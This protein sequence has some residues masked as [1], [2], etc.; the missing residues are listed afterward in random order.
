MFENTPLSHSSGNDAQGGNSAPVP[1]KTLRTPR[2]KVW[3]DVPDEQWNDWRWQLKNRL[4]T[5]EELAQVINLTESEMKALRANNLF[6][7]DITPYFAALI[8]PNDPNC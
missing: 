4:N 5:V 7:V 2:P 3:A 1:K 6:R 8:D